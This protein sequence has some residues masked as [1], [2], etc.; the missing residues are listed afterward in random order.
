VAR[1]RATAHHGGAACK[2]R[3]L[4]SRPEPRA[5]RGGAGATPACRTGLDSGVVRAAR[6]RG[7]PPVRPRLALLPSGCVSKRRYVRVQTNHCMCMAIPCFCS[8]HKACHTDSDCTH[9]IFSSEFRYWLPYYVV[10]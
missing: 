4:P 7:Q 3:A 2:D 9:T 10:L 6:I 1:G 8:E 5:L